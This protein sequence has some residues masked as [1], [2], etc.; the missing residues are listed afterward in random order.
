MPNQQDF[1]SNQQEFHQLHQFQQD[2][3]PLQQQEYRDREHGIR[4]KQDFLTDS[5]GRRYSQSSDHQHQ[6]DSSSFHRNERNNRCGGGRGFTRNRRDRYSDDHNIKQRN[7]ANNRKS[8]SQ[9]QQHHQSPPEILSNSRPLLQPPDT[10]IIL[11]EKGMPIGMPDFDQDNNMPPNVESQEHDS[12]NCQDS[13][14]PR[15]ASH[16]SER[17]QLQQDYPPDLEQ[18]APS[19]IGSDDQPLINQVTVIP[20]TADNTD[21]DAQQQNQYVPISEYEEHV[22]SEQ[23]DLAEKTN[24]TDN[25]ESIDQGQETSF[26]ENEQL[27]ES[28]TSANE[29]K[30]LSANGNFDEQSHEEGSPKKRALLPNGPHAPGI[31]SGP[32]GPL[33]HGASMTEPHP[34]MINEYDGPNF[35]PRIGAPFP[36][37]RGGPPPSRGGRGGFRGGP[38]PRGPWMD[39]GPP[40]GPAA[41]NFSPRGLKR[42]GGQFRGGGGFRGRGRGSNW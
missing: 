38:P 33:L 25:S 7:L 27:D 5:P 24:T 11:D 32:N 18:R 41:G 1:H 30:K 21:D 15:R 29:L 19:S 34:I 40:R 35:R 28:I 17:N 2:F 37:W 10:C 12:E 39:R 22:E 13:S 36:P 31:D 42:G 6:R 3:H 20:I 9:D 26:T 4:P 23:S 14:M 8:R 16:D